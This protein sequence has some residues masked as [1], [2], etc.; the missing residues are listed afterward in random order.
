[1]LKMHILP[2]SVPRFPL[3]KVPRATQSSRMSDRGCLPL[4]LQIIYHNAHIPPLV[5]YIC[6]HVPVKKVVPMCLVV[7]YPVSLMTSLRKCASRGRCGVEVQ[8]VATSSRTYGGS[9][10]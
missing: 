9:K 7:L 5:I 3:F 10:H 1:M 2:I 8:S 6:H 4:V